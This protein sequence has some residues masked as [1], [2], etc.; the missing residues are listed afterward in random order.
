MAKRTARKSVSGGKAVPALAPDAM[1]L[2]AE[3]HGATAHLIVIGK[4]LQ[5][6][7]S[8]TDGTL[9]ILDAEDIFSLGAAIEESAKKAQAAGE[10]LDAA[11]ANRN[12]EAANHG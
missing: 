3:I 5:L 11:R 10:A 6:A 7:G 1:Q 2:W 4:L 9:E 8:D 12:A